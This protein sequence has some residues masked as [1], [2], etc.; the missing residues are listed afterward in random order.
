MRRSIIA[1]VTGFIFI[2]ALSLGT[3]K[4]VHAMWPEMFYVGRTDNTSVLALT[5]A[6]VAVYAIAGCYIA[7]RLAP[8]RPLRHALILGVL[9]LVFTAFGTASA[10]D[11]APMWYRVASLALVI[12]YAYVGGLLAELRYSAIQASRS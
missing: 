7:G 2:G 11:T 9:G 3:D 10:W 6:Y 12:P 4:L 5:L 8:S 1:I